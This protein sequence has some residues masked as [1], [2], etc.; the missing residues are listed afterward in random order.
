MFYVTYIETTSKPG[1]I[2][3]WDEPGEGRLK[4]HINVNALTAD[5]DRHVRLP[6][7]KRQ[8]AA[9]GSTYPSP[10]TIG[11]VRSDGDLEVFATLSR[12][13]F[14]L[15]DFQWNELVN[16]VAG[17]LISLGYDDVVALHREDMPEVL[18]LSADE[19]DK[20]GVVV[21]LEYD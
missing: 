16:H 7:P 13:D 2:T 14:D 3:A 17:V 12:N 19:A 6:D 9:N 8:P 20:R 21:E 11:E 15:T 1:F 5:F 4:L 10:L 18:E